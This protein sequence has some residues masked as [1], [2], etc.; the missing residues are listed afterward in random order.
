MLVESPYIADKKIRKFWKEY[1]STTGGKSKRIKRKL[2][3]KEHFEGVRANYSR[4]EL[5]LE[6]A[7]VPRSFILAKQEERVAFVCDDV[8]NLDSNRYGFFDL[9][10]CT[11][12]LRHLETYDH[13][14]LGLKNIGNILKKDGILYVDSENYE[15]NSWNANTRRAIKMSSLSSKLSI[16]DEDRSGT[17]G[18][19]YDLLIVRKK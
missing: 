19:E 6:E 4:K 5:E 9:I 16:E 13:F 15:T 3:A 7:G 10:H 17:Q 18:K 12:V 1:L 14:I 8:L 11:N 2:Q